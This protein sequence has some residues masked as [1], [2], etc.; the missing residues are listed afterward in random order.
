MTQCRE[1]RVMQPDGDWVTIPA[2]EEPVRYSD[3]MVLMAT[4]SKIRDALVRHL[5][6]HNIPVQ[7]DRE[8]GLMQRPVVSDLDGLIQFIARPNSRFAAAWV[9]RSTLIGMS[10]AELQSFLDTRQDENLLHRLIEYSP[11]P[12]QLSLIH[13]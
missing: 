4:R 11:T 12:G 8:G 7:A 5:R 2:P 6:D 9:A 1:T 3:I 13:I 10:D